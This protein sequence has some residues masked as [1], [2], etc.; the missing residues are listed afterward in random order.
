MNRKRVVAM[1]AGTTEFWVVDADARAV[2]VTT[3]GDV[4]TF[5]HAETI[6]LE[7]VPGVAVSVD[8]IFQHLDL[9]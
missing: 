5:R 9:E 3:K 2:H 6:A 4:K 1:S 7:A 8:T